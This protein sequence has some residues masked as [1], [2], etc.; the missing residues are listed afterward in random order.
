MGKPDT[1]PTDSD[2]DYSTLDFIAEA[3]RPL[4]VQRHHQLVDE[5]ESSLSDALI[6]GEVD[7]PRLQ[8]MLREL[9]SES[10]LTRVQST[11]TA[12]ANDQHYVSANLRDALLEEL[13]LLRERGSIEIAT[14]Q[15]H[16]I[17]VYRSVRRRLE[18]RLATAPLLAE[19]RLLAVAMLVVADSAGHLPTMRKAL[20]DPAGEHGWAWVAFLVADLINLAQPG[21]WTLAATLFPISVTVN[22]A[23]VVFLCFRPHTT[24]AKP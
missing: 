9:D 19:L 6:T 7:N 22:A 14:L 1:D 2:S 18:E 4:L 20:H 24:G 21:E 3:R 8:A 17:G 5:M 10:E 23:I 13:C 12:L 16:V 15:L 11:I